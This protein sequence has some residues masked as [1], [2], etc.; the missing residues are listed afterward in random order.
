MWLHK[1]NVPL[2]NT[3]YFKRKYYFIGYI[4]YIFRLKL[5]YISS[6]ENLIKGITVFHDRSY[7]QQS[8]KTY[9]YFKIAGSAS[10]SRFIVK[11]C[12]CHSTF[13]GIIRCV[14]NVPVLER[15]VGRHHAAQFPHFFKRMVSH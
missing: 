2:G 14:P 5:Q 8:S 7:Y 10:R 15:C 9:N 12:A 11:A 3:S 4:C 6:R 13:L 1:K